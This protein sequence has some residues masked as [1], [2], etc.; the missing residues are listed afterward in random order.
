MESEKNNIKKVCLVTLFSSIF[1]LLSSISAYFLKYVTFPDA[2]TPLLIG[3][4]LL[5]ISGIIAVISK[6]VYFFNYICFIISGVALGFCINAWYIFRGF[7]NSLFLMCIIALLSSLY[8]VIFYL[9]SRIKIFNSHPNIFSILFVLILLI[10]YVFVII[11]TKT[12]FMST[13]GYYMI[14]EIAFT[15]AMFVEVQNNKQL[16]RNIVLST[17]SVVIVG[18]IIAI[19][20]AGGDLDIDGSFFDIDLNNKKKTKNNNTI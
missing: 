12:T 10:I 14:I 15:F 3:F 1:L 8:I 11:Y 20:M 6:K 4:G 13:F 16:F 7:N 19:I 2:W 18:I 9:F 17:F 5:I